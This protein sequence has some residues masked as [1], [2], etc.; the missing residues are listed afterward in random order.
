M[1]QDNHKTQ[2]INIPNLITALRIAGTCCLLLTPPL[3]PVFYGL[4]AFT[5]LTD[6]LDG[7]LARRMGMTS[8]FGAKLD[9]IA[10][11]LFYAVMLLRIF[12]ILY[13]TLPA[14]IWYAVGVV[15]LLRLSA[16]LVAAVKY[17]RFASLHTYLNKLTGVGVFLIPCVITLPIGIGACWII[18][19]I[20]AL[21]SAE[22][23]LI[24]LRGKS[25]RPNIKSLF[26]PN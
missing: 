16:Y 3:T 7:W 2:K 6:V 24:H 22:E 10:D 20:A 8:A 11:L 23:L 14:V 12:P 26:T 18:C 4:Y 5:G 25:Y 15:L 17:H 13:A 1:Q 19:V 21:S 9:S